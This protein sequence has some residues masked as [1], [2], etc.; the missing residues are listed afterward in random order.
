MVRMPW[1]APR[2]KGP[3]LLP[4]VVVDSGNMARGY[5]PL[6]R[7]STFY[8]LSMNLYTSR[9]LSSFVPVRSTY[10]DPSASQMV[11]TQITSFNVFFGV[12]L[13][14]RGETIWQ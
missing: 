5:S 7:T 9:S 2:L 12:K 11:R 10:I 13:G 4:L 8:C 1:N 14:C 6:L 3:I